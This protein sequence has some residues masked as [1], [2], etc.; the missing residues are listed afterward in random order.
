[1]VVEVLEIEIEKL[2]SF[3]MGEK[4]WVTK[5]IE[6]GIKQE[7]EKLKN[8]FLEVARQFLSVNFPIEKIMEMTGLSK[9]EIENLKKRDWNVRFRIRSYDN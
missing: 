3:V 2:P 9:D 6:I 8:N 4:K 5:G 1:M 7:R